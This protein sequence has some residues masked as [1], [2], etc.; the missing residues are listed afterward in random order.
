MGVTGY[1]CYEVHAGYAKCMKECV[2]GKDGTCL[3]HTVPMVPS[4]RSDISYSANTLF[5]FS[6]YAQDTGS[7]KKTYE[8]DLLRTQL[9]HGA[10]RARRK[11]G[12]GALTAQPR[13]PQQSTTSRNPRSTSTASR[14]PSAEVA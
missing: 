12:N 13:R 7:T 11:T 10:L 8:L 9:F 14:P 2:A 5:C 3:H 6:F 1:E 4:K